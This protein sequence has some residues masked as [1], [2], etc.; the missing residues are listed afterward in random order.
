MSTEQWPQGMTLRV[1]IPSRALLTVPLHWFMKQLEE[2]RIACKQLARYEYDNNHQVL[3]FDVYGVE[4]SFSFS[5]PQGQ[6]GSP[7]DLRWR[8]KFGK[9]YTHRSIGAYVTKFYLWDAR[10]TTAVHEDEFMA[11]QLEPLPEDVRERAYAA[12]QAYC[13]G[14]LRCSDCKALLPMQELPGHYFAGSYCSPCW[15]GERGKHKGTGG[16]KAVEARETYD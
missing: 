16:W 8:T 7:N 11:N 5:L 15:L 3:V 4:F 9:D 6:P 12:M 13:D 10:G 14:K 2:V 1:V